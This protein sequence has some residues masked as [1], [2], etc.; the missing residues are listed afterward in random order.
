[1]I[2]VGLRDPPWSGP[3]VLVFCRIRRG[4]E[5][6]VRSASCLVCCYLDH[7]NVREWPYVFWW[8]SKKGA[9]GR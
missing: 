8:R 2:G 3:A 9:C 4:Y 7:L 5:G 6:W 1:V